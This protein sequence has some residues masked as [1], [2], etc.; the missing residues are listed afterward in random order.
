MADQEKTELPTAK[1]LDDA[2]K[3]GQVPYSKELTSALMF[4]ILMGVLKLWGPNIGA[5]LKNLLETSLGF[6]ALSRVAVEG[7]TGLMASTSR[8][9]MSLLLPIL[10]VVLAIILLSGFLQ[11]GI[12]LRLERV[13]PQLSKLNPLSGI[14]KLFSSRSLFSVGLS[15]LK[16]LAVGIAVWITL[17]DLV[18]KARSLGQVGIQEMGSFFVAAVLTIGFRVAGIILVLALI[19]FFWTR[20]K[21]TKDLM[22]SKQEIKDE[23]RQFEGSP[24]IKQRIKSVRREVAL[25]RMMR[26][27]KTAT[28]VVRNPTHFAVALRYAKDKEPSPRVIAKGKNLMALRI[29][30]LALEAGVPVRSDPPLARQIYRNVP[31]GKTIPEELFQAVARV[32]AWVYRQNQ[33]AGGAV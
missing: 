8:Q 27:V 14:K 26:D 4:L 22:M 13:Q 2:S 28:V 5:K 7:V 21:H 1:R 25:A 15:L 31:L 23:Q 20:H 9:V 3:K 16:L 18:P 12:S 17:Q 30:N 24:E 10:G 32:L 19:D 33:K 29:I 11:I 6:E